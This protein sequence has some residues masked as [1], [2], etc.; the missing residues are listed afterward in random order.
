MPNQTTTARETTAAKPHAKLRLRMPSPTR[1]KPS[2]LSHLCIQLSAAL[3]AG[4]SLSESVILAVQNTKNTRLHQVLQAVHRNINSGASLSDSLASHPT[5]FNQIFIGMVR[6]GERNDALPEILERLATFLAADSNRTRRRRLMFAFPMVTSVVMFA[7][8]LVTCV[9]V[10]PAFERLFSD[11]GIMD[12]PPITLLLFA[13]SHFITSEWSRCLS[14]LLA[15]YASF[16]VIARTARGHQALNIL[17]LSLSGLGALNKKL[18]MAQFARTGRMLLVSGIPVPEVLNIIAD[19][20]IINSKASSAISQARALILEGE[21]IADAFNHSKYFPPMVINML[22]V[23]EQYSS[24]DL[25]LASIA[26]V[27]D[28]EAEKMMA[29]KSTVLE[30][31]LLLLFGLMLLMIVLALTMP[32]VV[33]NCGCLT[34]GPTDSTGGKAGDN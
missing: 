33:V 16:S 22:A 20:S 21:S 32:M 8:I 17:K 19:E 28:I 12:F 11:M 10:S 4:V 15:I 9:V 14:V 24:L 6:A 31:G 29:L 13:L 5:V 25:S 3:G 1:V 27:Y 18:A 30:V 34:D 23:G 7:A 2:D 26:D